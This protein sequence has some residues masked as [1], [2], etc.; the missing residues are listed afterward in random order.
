MVRAIRMSSGV[1]WRM[2]LRYWRWRLTGYIATNELPSFRF[3]RATGNWPWELTPEPDVERGGA[4]K[5]QVWH[6]EIQR[7]ERTGRLDEGPC[8][9]DDCVAAELAA[10][11]DG[12]GSTPEGDT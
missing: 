11:P 3:R 12:F 6:D 9:C 4:M 1:S 10:E 8:W 2:R 7:F 5:V